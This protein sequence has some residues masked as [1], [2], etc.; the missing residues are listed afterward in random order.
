MQ[1][2]VTVIC[3]ERM[4]ADRTLRV[5]TGCHGP[6][7]CSCATDDRFSTLLVESRVPNVFR[8]EEYSIRSKIYKFPKQSHVAF[9][10][11]NE[12][13]A[14][15]LRHHFVY[16]SN[17]YTKQEKRQSYVSFCSNSVMIIYF[18]MNLRVNQIFKLPSLF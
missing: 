18:F 11:F 16:E 1:C 14:F 10:F 12:K 8:D 6:S 4:T 9:F 15:T 7:Y 5:G 13:V 3:R 17:H 2:D